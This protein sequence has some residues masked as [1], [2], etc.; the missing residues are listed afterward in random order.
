MDWRIKEV[1]NLIIE[2][3][4]LIVGGLF[5]FPLIGVVGFIYSIL[6]HLFIKF[7]YS[8]SKQLI[9][10]VR[11]ITLA[12]DGLACACSGELLNDVLKIKSGI[13]Y[14]KWYHTI[15]AVTGLRLVFEKNDNKFRKV[16]DKILGK[17][18]CVDA[19]TEEQKCY[20]S[21]QNK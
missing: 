10:I 17:N 8:I 2:V 3:I 5:L 21:T 20:Y 9:P 4:F 11:S 12:S 1:K 13:N 16:L 19:I 6:K 14:G 15:S 18:H 7:D